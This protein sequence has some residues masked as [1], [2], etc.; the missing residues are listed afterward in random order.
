MGRVEACIEP[1]SCCRVP[2]GE[3]GRKASLLRIRLAAITR[4]W[5]LEPPQRANATSAAQHRVLGRPWPFLRTCVRGE[6]REDRCLH[7]CSPSTHRHVLFR[8]ARLMH[9]HTH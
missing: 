3:L 2:S 8:A 9:T 5:R 7:A 6:C 1:V 4:S